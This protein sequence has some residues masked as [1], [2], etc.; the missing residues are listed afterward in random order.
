MDLP[1]EERAYQAASR[2]AGS[3]AP[4]AAR[5]L[6]PI[7]VRTADGGLESWF[8]PVA[9]GDELIAYVRVGRG[10]P[11]YSVLGRP[12]PLAVWIDEGE[13]RRIVEQAGYRPRGT[14]YLGYDG[15]P[16]R[17]AWVVPLADGGAAY[18]AGGAVWP[19]SPGVERI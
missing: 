17:L 15:V 2:L 6:A 7:P 1:S 5:V 11:S 3:A 8:V 16:S 19:S 14:L 18:V 9:V 10:G 12:Q 4:S 13:V